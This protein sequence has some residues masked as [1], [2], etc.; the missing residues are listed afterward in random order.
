ML[1]SN[2]LTVSALTCKPLPKAL[3]AG[4]SSVHPPE[5]GTK[6]GLVMPLLVQS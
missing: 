3:V 1:G 5:H 6:Y 4:M 2:L